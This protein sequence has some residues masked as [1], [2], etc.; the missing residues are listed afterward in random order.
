MLTAQD[1]AGNESKTEKIKLQVDVL[2]VVTE[3]GLKIRVSNIEF[4][5]DKAE[6]RGKAFPILDRVAEF[7]KGHSN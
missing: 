3:R 5:F 6:L 1:R 2:V 4:S 7:E